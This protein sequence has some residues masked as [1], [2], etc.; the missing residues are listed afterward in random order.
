M[1]KKEIKKWQYPTKWNEANI[2]DDDSRHYGNDRL[3]L[4]NLGQASWLREEIVLKSLNNYPIKRKSIIG[5]GFFSFLLFVNGSI[6]SEINR[7]L[8]KEYFYFVAFGFTVVIGDDYGNELVDR[9]NYAAEF[10]EYFRLAI[11]I[12][13]SF[14]QL[15]TEGNVF[16]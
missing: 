4:S 11:S 9:S 10:R 6:N 1:T 13:F 14:L 5:I 8:N 16:S 15:D 12:N 2:L 3:I 7:W